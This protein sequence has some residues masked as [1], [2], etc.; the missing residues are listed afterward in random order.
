VRVE[1]MLEFDYTGDRI[2]D[3]VV[4]VECV[5]GAGSPPSQLFAFAATRSGPRLTQVLIAWDVDFLIERVWRIKM[6][7]VL[8]VRG[9]AYSSDDLP[10]CCPDQKW[11]FG[12]EASRGRFIDYG[13][14]QLL[15]GPEG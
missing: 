13:E 4:A 9:W 2:N 7:R 1:T 5:V 14:P 15:E 11:E 6:G 3:A 8:V 12:W 10:R